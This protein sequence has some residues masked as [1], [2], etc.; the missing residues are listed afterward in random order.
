MNIYDHVQKTMIH[1]IHKYRPKLTVTAQN[2]VAKQ[3]PF[4]YVSF[5]IYN[6][7]AM[8]GGSNNL[9]WFFM[10]IQMKAVSDKENEAKAL[11][12]WLRHFEY[13]QQP[14]LD[15]K[16]QGIVPLKNVSMVPNVNRF[17]Q[18]SFQFESGAD[19][20][21]GVYKPVIDTTQPGRINKINSHFHRKGD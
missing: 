18:N 12:Y 15:L 2:V 21:I 3:P 17:I 7:E 19:L 20:K 9:D 13:L 14:L 1:E 6:D 8:V 11:G 16:D 4:P 5:L 10:Q